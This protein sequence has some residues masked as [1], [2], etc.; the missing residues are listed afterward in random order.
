MSRLPDDSAATGPVTNPG[1]DPLV[2]VTLDGRF[3]V[4]EPIGK[5][6]MGRVYR[7]VQQPLNRPV[8][9]KVLD[10]SYGTGRDDTFRKRFLV[11]AELTA[12]L[13]HPNTVTIIDYGCTSNDL[14]FIAM[15]YLEGETLDER[16]RAYGALPW[17]RALSIGQQVA[18]SLLEAHNLGVVHR[19]LKPQN[20]MLLDTDDATDQVKV[21]DFGLVKSFITGQELE[22]RAVTQQGMLMGSPTY[23]APEQG[24][25]NISDPRSDI[26][27]L[28]VVLYECMSGKVPFSG[29]TSME[30]I[31][32]HVKAP[33][34]ELESP[35]QHEFI[36]SAVKALVM[37]CLAK[38]PMDR[39]QTLDE[40][41]SA[42]SSLS[43]EFP[44]PILTPSAGL[45][46]FTS[47]QRAQKRVRTLGASVAVLALGAIAAF[48]LRA[49]SSEP[50]PAA[51]RV[52]EKKLEGPAAVVAP[53]PASPPLR[54]LSIVFHIDTSPP[55]ATVMMNGESLGVTPLDVPV[56]PGPEG[57]A[58]AELTLVLD[59]HLPSTVKAAGMGPRIELLQTLTP[60]AQLTQA[61]A[62]TKAAAPANS[63]RIAKAAKRSK[64]P[65]AAPS[66]LG[67]DDVSSTGKSV[68]KR[69]NP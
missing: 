37:K 38:S 39:F 20:I 63:T 7:A 68:L 27:S 13:K 47:A 41:L 51:A 31:L 40:V 6:G 3:R 5:G 24:E 11:E 35:P 2:G 42:I 8:A 32:Q 43:T 33:V 25:H 52:E 45:P 61:K 26:Y 9:L 15:E 57:R 62:T 21:L 28:G 55:G 60:R 18:R 59:D 53:A 34:P 58:E 23:M 44:K 69:P 65:A 22:G 48:L 49:S 1:L 4:V 67:D 16:L 46:A 19:D 36:P 10:S 17:R 29:K 54:P 64:K 30:V 56:P 50:A 14:Y 66:K 12:K